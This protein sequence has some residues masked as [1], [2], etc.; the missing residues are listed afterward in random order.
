MPRPRGFGGADPVEWPRP[1]AFPRPERLE[2]SV[3]TLPGVGATI[4]RKLGKLGLETV[5]DLLCSAPFRHVGAREIASLFGDEEE[6]AIEVEVERMSKRRARGRLTIVE[7]T[8]S[9]DTGSIKA[10]WFNQPW[11]ADQ[12]QPGSRCSL[13]GT[14]RRGTFSVRSYER[15]G[16]PRVEPLV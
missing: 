12:L 4:K 16:E 3:D 1:R 8:V 10:V 6:V 9:D 5:G 7:A 15:E 2:R 13:I 14:I 11:V